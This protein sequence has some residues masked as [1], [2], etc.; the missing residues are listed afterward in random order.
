L[1]YLPNCLFSW[2]SPVYR[3]VQMFLL[4]NSRIH[5]K[6]LLNEILLNHKEKLYYVIFRKMDRTG[7]HHVE[8]EVKFKK[9]NSTNSH[10]FMESRPKV[11]VMMMEHE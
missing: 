5:L 11:V 6:N 2:I 10:L 3:W 7:D 4:P 9:P 8:W 1:A